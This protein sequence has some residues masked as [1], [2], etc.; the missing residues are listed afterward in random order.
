MK[1]KCIKCEAVKE[2]TGEELKE[3]GEFVE[4]RKLKAVG[5][6]KVLSLDLREE[7]LCTNGKSHVYEYDSDFDKEIHKLAAD[8]KTAKNNLKASESE[9]VE[10]ERVINEMTLKMEAAKQRSIENGDKTIGLLEK[11]KEIA[12]IGD[13]TLWS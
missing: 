2:L 5:F 7:N 11:M 10:C 9:V 13:E 1:L 8:I 12:W 3:V 4:K 6:L